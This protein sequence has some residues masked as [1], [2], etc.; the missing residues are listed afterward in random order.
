MNSRTIYILALS[1]FLALL[2]S[3]LSLASQRVALVIGNGA[4]SSAPLKNPPNDATDMANTLK[5]LGFKVIAKKNA[6]KRQMVDAINEFSR[7]LKNAEIGL[8]Y[9][10]GHGMQIRSQNYLIPVSVKVES[11]SDVEFEAVNAARVLGK[12]RQ[13]GNKLNV[14][15][16][17]AC[18]NN[19]FQRSFRTSEQGLARM[20]AP[21]GT[22]IAY[23][24]SPGSVAADGRGRNG[25]YTEHLLE[26]LKTPGLDIQNV[27]NEAG[28]KVMAD[29]SQKQVP[30]TSNTP[31]PRYYLAGGSM[32]IQERPT[33]PK[34]PISTP[35][36]LKVDSTPSGA[37]LYINGT[38]RGST[39][40]ELNRLLV[41]TLNLK[42][43]LAGYEA[44]EKRVSIRSNG[45][46][47]VSFVLSKITQSGWLTVN[48]EPVDAKVRILNI[49]PSYSSG[50]ALDPGRYH[51]EVTSQGYEEET[52]WV[53]LAAGESL[54]LD[55]V[56]KKS[57][58]SVGQSFTDPVTGMEFVWVP[59]GCYQMGKKDQHNE[60][61][62]CVSGLYVG[63]YEVTQ[64]EYK[65][66]MGKNP[67]LNNGDRN[68]VDNVSWNDTQD[69]IKMLNRKSGKFY[70][71]PTEAEW[72][73]AVRAGTL[74]ARYWGDSIDCSKAMY[75]HNVSSLDDKCF[76]FSRKKEYFLEAV[77]LS[78]TLSL[79]SLAFMI[80]W[81]MSRNGAMTGMAKIIMKSALRKTQ[82]VPTLAL[83][84]SFVEAIGQVVHCLL[85]QP[86]A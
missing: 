68:P 54:D 45:T 57:A 30:W 13:A 37:N 59:G 29:T 16:L 63:K 52:R 81:G 17:D 38:Y 28:M 39:P 76:S 23:A 14:V 3:S 61:R 33:M 25:L 55:I 40:V 44:E 79:I 21:V 69:F 35:G 46:S 67:S 24:T 20:D 78:V 7:S 71:L 75:E 43:E 2:H 26:A 32:V 53:N 41:G 8:F 48:T 51:L 11:E 60:H 36:S 72:E 64:E 73:Y 12:M 15:I 9:Y 62:V 1:I 27:F 10:A 74:T 86:L 5:S 66:V 56:L 50:M 31:I 4:Y 47:R 6:N 34:A 65:R 18:R 19:P 22:I 84:V 58:T 70:R 49:G 82:Q 42:V 77:F 80:C 85:L 83:S